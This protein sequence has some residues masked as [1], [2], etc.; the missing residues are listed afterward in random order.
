MCKSTSKP[1]SAHCLGSAYHKFY[2]GKALSYPTV[3]L[4]CTKC[5]G[6]FDRVSPEGERRVA[7]GDSAETATARN[8]NIEGV[9]R[10]GER[11]DDG[12]SGK[13]GQLQNKT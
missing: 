2:E 1:I 9:R 3:P 8:V 4:L 6:L 7:R 12:Y 10:R 13:R 5:N 11:R